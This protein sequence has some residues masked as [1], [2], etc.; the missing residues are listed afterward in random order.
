MRY[1]DGVFNR[2]EQETGKEDRYSDSSRPRKWW[3]NDTRS[4]TGKSTLMRL[5]RRY[6][7]R[8]LS[9]GGRTH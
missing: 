7:S 1:Q 2:K 8:V 6:R 9:A 5:L 4:G 3:N